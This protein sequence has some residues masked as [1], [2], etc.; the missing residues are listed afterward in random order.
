MLP[1]I[2]ATWVADAGGADREHCGSARCLVYMKWVPEKWWHWVLN[3]VVFARDNRIC[4]SVV[5]LA[6]HPRS[7][8]RQLRKGDREQ[9]TSGALPYDTFFPSP[10]CVLDDPYLS[11]FWL[12]FSLP[13]SLK[14]FQTNLPANNPF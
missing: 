11:D 6:L 3:W 13:T 8:D 10:G 4:G 9:A 1:E 7:L 12:T 14:N 5:E 2:G